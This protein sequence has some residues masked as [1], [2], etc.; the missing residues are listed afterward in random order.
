L[1]YTLGIN[2]AFLIESI[3]KPIENLTLAS[4]MISSS[5]K[6]L[7]DHYNKTNELL[8]VVEKYEVKIKLGY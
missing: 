3:E 1:N 8:E 2:F 7:Q 4:G 6:I 5:Y